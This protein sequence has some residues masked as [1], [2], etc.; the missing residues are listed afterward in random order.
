MDSVEIGLAQLLCARLCHDL[1]GPLGSVRGAVELLEDPV[2]AEEALEV[3]RDAAVVLETR[4]RLYRAALGAGL[5]DTAAD[6]LPA[7]LEG[8][9]AGRR[10]TVDASCLPPRLVL[11]GPLAQAVL[12]A[13]W[14]G[15]EALPRG[16]VVRLAAPA[17]DDSSD[18]AAVPREIAVCPDGPGSAWPPTLFAALAGGTEP[19]DARGLLAPALMALAAKAGLSVSLCFGPMPGAAPLLLTRQG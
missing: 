16:G 15:T 7:L 14:L 19:Y 12:V 8:A 4:L 5:G 6:G 3:V 2:A 11:P 17:A 18:L 9:V 10:V 1:G 13:A